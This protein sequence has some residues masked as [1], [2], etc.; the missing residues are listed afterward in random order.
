MCKSIKAL[1]MATSQNLA[2]CS[3]ANTC[4]KLE[5]L[6]KNT[7]KSAVSLQNFMATSQQN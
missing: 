1:M 3:G 7:I 4:E 5:I 6:H 2:I